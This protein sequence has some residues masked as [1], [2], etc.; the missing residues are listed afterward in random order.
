MDV[1]K[2]VPRY[3]GAAFLFVAIV[4]LI[5]G[6]PVLSAVGSHE[7]TTIFANFSDNLTAL[8]LS[9]LG[10]MITCSGIVVLA[11]LLYVVLSKQSRIIALIALGSWLLEAVFLAIDQMGVVA[12]L[13]LSQDFV[14]A[15]TPAG[16]FYQTLGDYVYHGVY[17]QG[18]LLHMWF[19]CA[20]GMLWYFL[21]YRSVYVPHIISL[22]GLAAVFVAFVGLVAEFMG[23][24]VSI[25][26]YLPLLP[27]ELTLGAWLAFRGINAAEEPGRQSLQRTA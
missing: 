5:S 9:V 10:Q 16:S 14:N 26:M 4:P 12:L 13:R 2:N 1:D 20:G 22:F 27:F 11:T 25:V 17:S 6:I 18:S 24:D 8:R 19:Y 21:F 3:L 7:I 23:Y 15:G